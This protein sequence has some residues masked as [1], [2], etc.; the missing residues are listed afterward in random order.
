M[1]ENRMELDPG[2]PNLVKALKKLKKIYCI[3]AE[4]IFAIFRKG[5]ST[6]VITLLAYGILPA[7]YERR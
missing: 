6:S 4:S 2:P 7:S 3:F 1:S 5:L